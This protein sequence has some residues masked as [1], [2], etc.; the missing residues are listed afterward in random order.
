MRQRIKC[1]YTI[2]RCP[3]TLFTRPTPS[4]AS[5]GLPA[6]IGACGY[7]PKPKTMSLRTRVTALCALLLIAHSLTKAQRSYSNPSPEEQRSLK[8]FLRTMDHNKETRYI[9]A[10]PDLDDD[11]TPEAIV[12]MM[13]P[14]WCGSGGCNLLVL[15]RAGT[16]WK[17]VTELRITRPPI[18]VLKNAS[19]GWHD[20]T[21]WVAGGGI[22]PGYEAQL[23]FN[24]KTYPRNPSVPPARRLK[25]KLPGAVVIN[26]SQSGIPLYE[27]PG[28]PLI[29]H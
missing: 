7:N 22:N 18:R 25:E 28:R 21:V 9:A 5:A 2:R 26:S 19:N 24:G 14:E 11:G 12:Y 17:T 6:S 27:D 13:G 4:R 10:F 8:Q 23:R 1:N 15:K 29:A 16:V 20:I 3:K